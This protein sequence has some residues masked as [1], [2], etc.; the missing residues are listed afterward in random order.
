MPKP[1]PTPTPTTAPD[2]ATTPVTTPAPAPA[3]E[4]VFPEGDDVIGAA[5]FILTP[6]KFRTGTTDERR[7]RAQIARKVIAFAFVAVDSKQPAPWAGWTVRMDNGATQ[8][9]SRIVRILAIGEDK[10]LGRIVGKA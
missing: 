10:S 2:P 6:A 9:L 7:I 8:P 5:K 1:T 3:P 4:I